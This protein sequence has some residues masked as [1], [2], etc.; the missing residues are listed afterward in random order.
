MEL[1]LKTSTDQNHISSPRFTLEPCNPIWQHG[2][3]SKH[4]ILPISCHSP[5]SPCSLSPYSS[6]TSTL[7]K[8]PPSR[9]SKR[10]PIFSQTHIWFTLTSNSQ[11][12]D[13]P[14]HQMYSKSPSHPPRHQ[15]THNPR[16]LNQIHFHPPQ[17][18]PF[19][20]HRSH[21]R[22]HFNFSILRLS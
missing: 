4:L 5:I 9:L 10:N 13:H 22:C 14:S 15:A 11:F 20:P 3:A 7:T 16:N 17:R 21:S 1:K 6:L 2:N 18:L 8:K 19:H 12:T